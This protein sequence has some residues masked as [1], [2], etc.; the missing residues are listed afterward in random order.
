MRN[1]YELLRESESL[2]DEIENL[3]YQNRLLSLVAKS[4]AYCRDLTIIIGIVYFVF[5]SL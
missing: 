5:R 3:D 2:Q 4:A 1:K